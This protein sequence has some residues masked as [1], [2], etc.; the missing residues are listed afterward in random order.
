MDF[1]VF[2]G[3][4]LPIFY[5]AYSLDLLP[6][7]LDAHHLLSPRWWACI[8][9]LSLLYALHAFIWNFP[10][11]FMHLCGRMPLRLL[12]AHP[13]GADVSQP[14]GASGSA[15]AIAVAVQPG[16]GKRLHVMG[17]RVFG[18]GIDKPG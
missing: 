13:V 14:V 2:A 17:H 6:A 5:R 16:I 9:G 7:L 11:R 18:I 8:L 12:G 1:A 4:L 3:A 15:A 10:V